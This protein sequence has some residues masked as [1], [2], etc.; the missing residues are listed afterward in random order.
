MNPRILIIAAA[1]LVTAVTYAGTAWAL[2]EGEII[3]L[4]EACMHGDRDACTHRDTAIH[5]HD[6]ESE[7]R[8][9]HPEWYR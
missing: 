6:H 3:R 7:W 1:A 5:D 9:H 8:H 2:T 4:H